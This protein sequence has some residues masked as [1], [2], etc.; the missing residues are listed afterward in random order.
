MAVPTAMAIRYGSENPSAANCPPNEFQVRTATCAR[1]RNEDH[2]I[3]GPTENR[4]STYPVFVYWLGLSS[5][6]PWSRALEK[7]LFAC[8]QSSSNRK[9][10]CIK[11]A[12]A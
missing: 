6:L 2:S 8:R 4:L 9:L 3:A 11:D 12:R 5:S 7:Y 10:C 1:I